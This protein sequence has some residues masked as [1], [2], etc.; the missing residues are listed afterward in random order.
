MDL[1]FKVAYCV[2]VSMRWSAIVRVGSLACVLLVDY[3]QSLARNMDTSVEAAQIIDVH[4]T[5]KVKGAR[6]IAVITTSLVEKR[7]WNV[8]SWQREK[9]KM[10]GAKCRRVQCAGGVFIVSGL[11]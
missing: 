11:P 6:R 9:R 2:I 4:V 3:Q 1:L 8:Q 7:S 5:R 10:K